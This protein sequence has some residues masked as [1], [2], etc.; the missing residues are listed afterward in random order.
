MSIFGRESEREIAT[1]QTIWRSVSRL[2]AAKD[3][4]LNLYQVPVRKGTAIPRLG[5]YTTKWMLIGWSALLLLH[6]IPGQFLVGVL[7]SV[8]P[9]KSCCRSQCNSIAL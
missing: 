1:S 7:H 5:D 6:S 4:R 8:P 2:Q 3:W 9:K